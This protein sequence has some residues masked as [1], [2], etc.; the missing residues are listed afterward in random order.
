MSPIDD[1]PI[2]TMNHTP[3][4]IAYQGVPGAYSQLAC[5]HVYPNTPTL[6]C[7][8]F[9]E[10]ME[11]V[12]HGEVELAM[13]PLENS[14][15]GRVEEI[16]RQIPKMCLHIIAEHF[17]PVNHCLLALPGTDIETLTEVHSHPQ[18][19]AQCHNNLHQLGLHAIANADT[20]GAA[21]QVSQGQN[22]HHAAISSC[23]AAEL[24]NLDILQE[25]FQDRDGN[26]TRFVILSKD[27]HLPAYNAET[28]Y[29]T[30]FI[31][32]VRNI[33]AALYK[34]LGGFATNGVNL[35]K[36]ES[37]MP[38]GDFQATQFYADAEAH[39]DT[40]SMQLAMHELAY[41][42]EE[43]RILGTY[44]IHSFRFNKTK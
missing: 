8:T 6:A 22:K 21:L 9:I 41:F 18:A 24:Y 13:I 12:E 33:P 28:H 29:I 5:Q 35:V 30:S 36:L 27:A 43:I 34:G 32:R 10:A 44:P 20:A 26:T 15:A 31:F 4:C 25:N 3:S 19:L 1:E 17:E 37:Y 42:A 2:K 7:S 14:T 38:D 39:P 40:H 11:K 16:Y 23:L